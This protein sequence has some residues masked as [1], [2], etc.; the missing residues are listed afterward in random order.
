M[1]T[2]RLKSPEISLSGIRRAAILICQAGP[3]FRSVAAD[4][5][6]TNL[7]VMDRMVDRVSNP[8]V[9]LAS[10]HR[11]PQRFRSAANCANYANFPIRVIG[12]IRG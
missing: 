2:A 5:L 7:F 11:L 9:K 8:Y 4:F 1:L 10:F 6:K 12:G 3:P